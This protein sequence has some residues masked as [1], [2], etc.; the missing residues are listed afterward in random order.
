MRLMLE[1][2]FKILK[3]LFA[4]LQLSVPSLIYRYRTVLFIE[5]NYRD[6]FSHLL[7]KRNFMKVI[8]LAE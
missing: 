1:F 6:V 8:S 3:S 2:E 5:Y 7:M 4:D